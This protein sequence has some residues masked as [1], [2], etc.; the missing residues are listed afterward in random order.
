MVHGLKFHRVFR[1]QGELKVSY[2]WVS[3]LPPDYISWKLWAVIRAVQGC[4][5]QA[6]TFLQSILLGWYL[7]SW[8]FLCYYKSLNVIK[9]CRIVVALS[10]GAWFGMLFVG[11]LKVV[12]GLGWCLKFDAFLPHGICQGRRFVLCKQFLE[13]QR[14]DNAGHSMS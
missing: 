12:L 6:N 4:Q 11:Y 3:W 2:G 1:S 9:L 7:S 8:G 10:F 13:T 14:R 5:R